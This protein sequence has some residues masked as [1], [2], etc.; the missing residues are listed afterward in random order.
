VIY[1]NLITAG[2]DGDLFSQQ[3]R[4]EPDA[5]LSRIQNG[6]RFD[7]MLD[8]AELLAGKPATLK[9]HLTDDRT[10]E[11][12]KDLQ[13]YLGAWGHTLIISEDARAYVHSHPLLTIPDNADRNKIVGGADI[14]FDAFFPQ[15]GTYRVWSQFQRRGK[16][17]TVSFTIKVRR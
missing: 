15:P 4:L 6:I 13:P 14:A 17:I 10:G 5:V 9:Y 8:P 16:V 7:L 11:P 12:V 1:R 2:F 3:A